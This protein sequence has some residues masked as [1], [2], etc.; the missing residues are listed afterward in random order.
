MLGAVSCWPF[1]KAYGVERL[2]Q[3]SV[4]SAE[5][6]YSAVL[7]WTGPYAVQLKQAIPLRYLTFCLW[8]RNNVVQL[9][10]SWQLECKPHWKDVFPAPQAAGIPA[11]LHQMDLI[12]PVEKDN[13]HI[14]HQQGKRGLMSC[15]RAFSVQYVI[16]K[17]IFFAKFVLPFAS[18]DRIWCYLKRQ[19]INL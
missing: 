19:S 14:S 10:K 8:R 2:V 5:Q 15:F 3:Q 11:F 13:Q 6:I 7:D 12:R 4:S 1:P 9:S 16:K 18:F 17:T